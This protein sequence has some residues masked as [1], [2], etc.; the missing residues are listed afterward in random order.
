MRYQ[1]TCSSAR[2][3]AFLFVGAVACSGDDDLVQPPNNGTLEITTSTTG[4]EM[5]PDGYTV[6]V[7][8]GDPQTIGVAGTIQLTDLTSG[9]HTV[10]LDGLAGNCTVAGE[11]PRTISITAGETT[12]LTLEVSCQATTGGL[13]VSTSTTGQS[14]DA[15]GYTVLVDG[16]DRGVIAASSAI[17]LDGVPAGDHEVGLSG[18]AVNCQVSGANPQTVTVSGGASAAVAFTV[19]CVEV[20]GGNGTLRITT[21]TSG[22]DPDPNGYDVAVDVGAA[23][24][25]GVNA[26]TTLTNV[27]AGDHSVQLSGVATNCNVQG[28]NPRSI[29][30]ASG[31]TAEVSF[32]VSCSASTGA[33]EIRTTTTGSNPDPDGYTVSIDGGQ[34]QSIGVNATL[35]VTGVG[36]GAHTVTL[37]GLATNCTVQGSNP[38]QVTITAGA[39][40]S[41]AFAISCSASPPGSSWTRM[42]SGTTMP[43][44]GVSGSSATNVFAIAQ[45][46]TEGCGIQC[47]EMGILHFNGSTWSTQLTHGGLVWDVWAAPTGEAFVLVEPDSFPGPILQYDGQQ[48]SSPA[49][50]PPPSP[51]E[52]D[53]PEFRGI[54]GSSSSDIFAVASTRDPVDRE[55][56]YIAHY[57]GNEWSSM[58]VATELDPAL[59]DVWGSSATDVYAVGVYTG[60]ENDS[61]DNRAV[62]LHYNG[63]TWSE[64]LREPDLGLVS[65]WGTSANDVYAVGVTPAGNGAVWHYDGA[66]WSALPIPRM[67][68]LRAIWGSSSRDIYVA[69]GDELWH[70]DGTTWL[71]ETEV[72]GTDLFD[73]WSSSATD[74]FVVGDGGTI[75]HGP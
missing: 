13:Q 45:E 60:S 15:D 53:V 36:A 24:P 32:T 52:G 34:A 69:G 21:A 63:V 67:S 57:N 19:T 22:P 25:I 16:T 56:A 33:L 73:V 66:G 38:Q 10:Q 65:L 49:A 43:L 3:L 39:S 26:A 50:Q 20:P 40:A 48:W 35:S 31:A 64:V 59:L 47:F 44:V 11:N 17:T 8:A 42:N 61:D 41:A 55:H 27:S 37:A 29:S 1:K 68:G 14:I 9:N 75:L 58:E 23:Q 72:S 7:D 6:R 62:I 71:Q 74:V 2:W 51:F 18:I 28:S 70:Y 54:W 5:D 4:V 30:V 12:S 46:A